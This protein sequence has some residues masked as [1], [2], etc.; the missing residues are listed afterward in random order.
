MKKVLTFILAT[1]LIVPAGIALAD[2]TTQASLK[3][4]LHIGTEGDMQL[5]GFVTT[6]ADSSLTV[7]GWLG[8]WTIATTPSTKLTSQGATT[9]LADIKIGDYVVV[10]GALRANAGQTVDASGINIRITAEPAHKVMLKGTLHAVSGTSLTLKTDHEDWTV[11]TS[12]DTKFYSRFGATLILADLK[13]GDSLEVMGS[14]KE[15]TQFTL[16]AEQVRDFSLPLRAGALRGEITLLEPLTLTLTLMTPEK[17]SFTVTLNG[18]TK[19]MVGNRVMTFADL[20]L[21]T[22]ATLQ[23]FIDAD[24]KTASAT[25]IRIAPQPKPKAV[26]LQGKITSETN[27]SIMLKNKGTTTKVLIDDATK[28]KGAKTADLD[29]GTKVVVKGFLGTD[30]I[31]DASTITVTKAKAK[32]KVSAKK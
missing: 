24:T 18:D 7:K 23:G 21:G 10:R 26:T 3:S 28:I 14:L 12:A 4:Y 11:M 17:T 15:G 9:T 29:V 30:G 16:D 2:T 8:D 20:K 19:I 31:L 22:H 32:A 5:R 25:T 1:A 6:K 27:G 13:T